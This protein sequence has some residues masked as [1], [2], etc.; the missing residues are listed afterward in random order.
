MSGTESACVSG[1]TLGPLRAMSGT[2][3]AYAL[4]DRPRRASVIGS[5]VQIPIVLAPAIHCPVLTRIAEPYQSGE[6]GAKPKCAS[7]VRYEATCGP[8][9]A[10]RDVQYRDRLWSYACATRCPVQA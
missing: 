8:T 3:I 7:S 2:E 10:L 5:A 9:R 6:K 1:T 4:P